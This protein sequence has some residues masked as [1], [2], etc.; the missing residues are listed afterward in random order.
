[1]Y[2]LVN[3]TS[4]T[5]RK[6]CNAWG[7]RHVFW[8]AFVKHKSDND[9]NLKALNGLTSSDAYCSAFVL[10]QQHASICTLS[11][12]QMLFDQQVANTTT[13]VVSG[14]PKG[15]PPANGAAINQRLFTSAVIRNR[16]APPSILPASPSFTV[17]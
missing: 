2:R 15:N 4:G 17:Q 16:P 14:S 11:Y 10:V 5:A 1:L 13:V 7:A 8:Q 3:S 12:V 6:G 9:A